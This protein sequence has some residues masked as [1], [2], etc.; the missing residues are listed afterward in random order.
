MAAPAAA[1]APASRLRRENEELR[2]RTGGAAEL[3]GQSQ[4]I[5]HIRQAIDRVAPTGSRVLVTGPAG[6]GKEVVARLVH[7]H[8]RRAEGPSSM[9]TPY[10]VLIAIAICS[11]SRESNAKSPPINT[12]SS[13]ISGKATR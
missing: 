1:H 13:A 11:A 9:R 3:V 10:C 2:L 7:S 6:A 8:S 5:G 12:A 4:A